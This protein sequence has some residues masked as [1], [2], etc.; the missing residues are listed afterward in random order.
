MAKLHNDEKVKRGTVL[1][2]EKR[3]HC[4]GDLALSSGVLLFMGIV[5]ALV[6]WVSVPDDK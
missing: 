6:S 4:L 1:R 5:E 2:L 3:G